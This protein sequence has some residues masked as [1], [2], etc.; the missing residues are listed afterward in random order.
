[1]GNLLRNIY[2]TEMTDCRGNPF[3]VVSYANPNGSFGSASLGQI[4]SDGDPRIIQLAV[5]FGF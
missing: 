2:V 5:R 1:M 3:I 4:T